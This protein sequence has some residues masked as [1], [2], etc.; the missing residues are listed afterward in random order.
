MPQYQIQLSL[1]PQ[2]GVLEPSGLAVQHTLQDLGYNQL[3]AVTMGKL[4]Q[5]TINAKDE[6]TAKQLA[7]DMAK[8]LLAHPLMELAEILSCQIIT[9]T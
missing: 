3:H 9:T 7:L 2:T 8:T 1:M 4:I 6:P 5:L